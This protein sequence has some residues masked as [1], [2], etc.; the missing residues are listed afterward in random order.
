MII[1]FS[2]FN[3]FPL[4]SNLASPTS[5]PTP[6]PTKSE[7]IP[8]K[9]KEDKDLTILG[10]SITLNFFAFIKPWYF[11]KFLSR[12]FTLSLI[13]PLFIFF[14]KPYAD[15]NLPPSWLS[16]VTL[17]N[18]SDDDIILTLV[19]PLFNEPLPVIR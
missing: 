14:V 9:L 19:F 12:K 2:N 4:F 8:E 15:N 5:K 10:A 16:K 13:S 18:P 1:I 11:D 3:S 6:S 17:G 7:L